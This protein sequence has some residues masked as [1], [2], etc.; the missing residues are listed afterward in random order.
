MNIRHLV[1]SRFPVQYVYSY[2][3]TRSYQPSQSFSIANAVFTNEINVYIHIPFCNQKCSF[4]GYL[5]VIERHEDE[6]GTYVN[7]LVKEIKNFEPYVENGVLKT[8]NFGGGTPSLLSNTQVDKIMEALSSVFPN[9]KATCTEVSMEATPE[10]VS[11]ELLSHLRQWGFNRISI[12]IQTLDNHEISAV[13]RHNF[14]DDSLNA[15]ELV[16]KAGIP[17]LCIDLMYGLPEQTME[18]W[19]VTLASIIKYKPETIELYR[20]VVIPKTGLS[21][22]QDPSLRLEW[23]KRYEAYVY[24]SQVLF[25]SGYQQDS[26]LRFVVPTKG[27]Y[28][29]QSNVFAGQ[30][31]VG[32]GVGARSYADN[33][34]YRNIYST[35]HSKTAV[36]KYIEHCNQGLPTIESVTILTQEELARRY[37]IYNLEYLDCSYIQKTY[38]FNVL[39]NYYNEIMELRGLGIY[40][41]SGSVLKLTTHGNYHRDLIAYMFFSKKSI[42]LEKTYYGSFLKDW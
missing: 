29:Q 10:S 32:F 35:T 13:K 15:I 36:K 25:T 34:H 12:G 31:L 30:S 4:C 19:Q 14:S 20:T 21:K 41:K 27:F 16:R 6:R 42:E 8:I 38:G 33:A 23:E 28:Y 26:H 5:T 11:Y 37:I 1:E 24:A 3:T 18:S 7:A 40:T 22:K 9:Y 17:N 39:V 2:P